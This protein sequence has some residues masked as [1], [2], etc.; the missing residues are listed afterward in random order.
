MSAWTS[1]A[2]SGRLQMRMFIEEAAPAL[3][4]T[5]GAAAPA[6]HE[7]L[8]VGR[9]GRRFA[10][11]RDRHAVDVEDVRLGG[12]VEHRGQVRPLVVSVIR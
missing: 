8:R 4:T 12:V 3:G 1:P 7:C 11:R 5:A 6:E 9:R 10:L 2:L